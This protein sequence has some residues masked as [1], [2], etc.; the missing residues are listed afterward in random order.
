MG[1][2]VMGRRD[3]RGVDVIDDWAGT[4]WASSAAAP[5]PAKAATGPGVAMI[6]YGTPLMSRAARPQEMMKR[7]QLAYHTNPWVKLAE[8][9]VV[10]RAVGLPWHLEDDDDAETEEVDTGPVKVVRDL[11]E[12]PQKNIPVKQPAVSTRRGLT[13]LTLR[14]V[15]LCGMAHWYLDQREALT[16][17]PLGILYI[18]PARMYPIEDDAGNLVMW[19]LD[20]RSFGPRGEPMGGLGLR[21][22]EV[23]TFYL[24]PPDAGNIGTGIYEAM[25][26]KAQLTNLS[27]QHTAYVL[28]TGG[29]MAGILAPKEGSLDPVQMA[30]LE[31]E[32]RNAAESSDAAKR[33]TIVAGPV[34]WIPTAADPSSLNQSEL[35]SM[36]RDDILIGW[37]VPPETAGVPAPAG[38]GGS[39]RGKYTE[40]VLMQGAVHDRVQSYREGV[41]YGLLDGIGLGIQLEIEEPT[42]DDQSPAYEIASKARELPLT[43]KERRDLVGLPPFGTEQ[44]PDPRDDEIWLPSGLTLVYEAGGEKP[45]SPLPP[46]NPFVAPVPEED[47]EGDEE[48]AGKASQRDFLGLRRAQE[49][50]WIPPTQR[51]VDAV[52]RASRDEALAK[53]RRSS[54]EIV[55]RH[56][57]DPDY[58]I[59]AKRRSELQK[60]LE[61][62]AG[63]IA[64]TV[65]ERTGELIGPKGKA[66]PF[67]DDVAK[68]VKTRTAERVVEIDA[69]TRKQLA[70]AIST[71][72]ER[73]MSPLEIAQGIEDASLVEGLGD[74]SILARAERIA[75]TETM[76]AY[77][78][79]AITSYKHYGVEK[80]TAIDG[81]TDEVCASRNG[82]DFPLSE[83]WE[84][85]DHPNG[86][87]DWAPLL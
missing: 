12:R 56:R 50:R 18:N 52:L 46:P 38:L 44:K 68:T 28:G 17:I 8:A 69:Y 3:A 1:L 70:S 39:E 11:L 49:T 33:M 2:R 86:T 7:A 21:L 73:G 35:S 14:H 83:A 19:M 31:R 47:S 65:S 57:S 75:R 13:S 34:D 45:P 63:S 41:Q 53:L 23:L 9:T 32:M 59:S 48:V 72:W 66:D 26:V 15:G 5:A 42:F 29:R 74:E 81:D 78:D 20:P 85:Q 62:T 54:P 64:V 43:N 87:L 82:K 76:F 60:I 51:K 55:K 24:D 36:N 67:A 27:D 77:N 80:V 16:G 4:P 61:D 22:D 6:Q 40:A 71:G 30:T 58:W 10:R 84:I 25:T 37:G 79:A